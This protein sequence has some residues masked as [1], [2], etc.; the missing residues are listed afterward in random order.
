MNRIKL[1][2]LGLGSRSTLFYLS[3]L[4][5]AYQNKN[6]G[7][8][9]YPLWLLN[10]DFNSINSLLPNPSEAL[11]YVVSDYIKKIKQLEVDSILIPNITLHETIDRLNINKNIVHPIHLS[12][13][14][15]KANLCKEVV[16]FG[17]LFSMKSNYI[18]QHFNAAGIAIISPSESDMQLIDTV[19]KEI[20]NQTETKDLIESY[21]QVIAKYN[22]MMPVILACTELSILKPKDRNN[23]IDMVDLQVEHAVNINPF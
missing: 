6:G 10:T 23:L 20:Y 7:Y 5:R 8:S 19:R 2:V 17:S 13:S 15:I 12:I 11:D 4:N 21:H 3:E 9:T 14:K 16:L 1:A 22:S 18:S